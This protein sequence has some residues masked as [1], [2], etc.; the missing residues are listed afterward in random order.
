MPHVLAVVGTRPDAI[1]MAPVILE[2]KKHADMQTAVIA[3]GQHKEMLQQVLD[4]FGIRVDGNF[5]VMRHGQTLA[6]ITSAILT[7]LDEELDKRKPDMVVAQGDTTTTFVAGMAAF[8]RQIPFAHVEAGLRTQTVDSPFPEEFNR[9][10]VSQVTRLHFAPTSAAAANLLQERVPPENVFVTGNTSI[11]AVLETAARVEPAKPFASGRMVLVT[12]HRRENWGEP[13]R[14]ICRALGRLMEAVPEAY[15]V[16]PMHK[17]PVVRDVLE[18][19]LGGS[20]RV[21]LIEPPDYTEFTRLMLASELILTDSGGVQEEAPSLGKPVLVLRR[22]TERPEG[23]DAGNAHLVGTD[24]EEIFQQAVTLLTDDDAY[25][26]MAQAR[27]PYGD[28][29]AAQRI[30]AEI[31]GYLRVSG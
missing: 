7:A 5:E 6:Y 30:V 21:F 22:E 28:G 11:D 29:K 1:K 2:L 15:V 17:N 27:N 3:S 13:Q 24:E 8:Y 16:L 23:I 26:S 4:V 12:T 20:P 31:R 10:C 18:G 25:R 19:E 9:R 14:A